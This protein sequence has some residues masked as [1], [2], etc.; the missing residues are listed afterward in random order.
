ME[1]KYRLLSDKLTFYEYK[2]MPAE[3]KELWL[4]RPSRK[5]I[6]LAKTGMYFRVFL[7]AVVTIYYGNFKESYYLLGFLYCYEFA[8]YSRQKAHAEEAYLKQYLSYSEK[9]DNLILNY[10]SEGG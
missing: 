6:E 5:T 7:L 10:P 1:L 4:S 3:A 9:V 8:Y 2:T